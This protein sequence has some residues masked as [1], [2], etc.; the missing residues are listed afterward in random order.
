MNKVGRPD[1]D[2]ADV[3]EL[4]SNGITGLADLKGRFDSSRGALVDCAL[5]YEARAADGRVYQIAPFSDHEDS[6]ALGQLSSADLTKLYK[7]YFSA[8]GK[9]AR[10]VYDQLML[11]AKEH[12]PFC[13]GIGRP[14]TLDH[15]L[16][17]VH[18]PAYAVSPSNLVPSCKDCNM[19]EKAEFY[20]AV[21]ERQ[22]IHPYWEDE[23][24]FGQQWVRAKFGAWPALEDSVVEYFVDAPG[25]WL[26]EERERVKNHFEAFDLPKRFSV[27][28]AEQRGVVVAQIETMLEDGLSPDQVNRL[29]LIPAING[30][31]LPNA[32]LKCM[33]QAFS[34]WLMQHGRVRY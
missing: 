30:V 24:F 4:C 22:F 34:E 32:W 13:G 8:K 1:M 5:D 16:P 2:Y 9:P 17:K 14:T 18:F 33:Y 3:L 25:S 20:S 7:Q 15:F 6:I 27:K 31:A 11:A 23:K 28:A 19:G 21:Y 29:I 12:C 26:A 10:D